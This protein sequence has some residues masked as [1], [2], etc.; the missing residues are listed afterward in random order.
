MTIRWG[1]V[2]L[3]C[4][5]IAVLT[6]VA[7]LVAPELDAGRMRAPLESALR[8]T[9]GRP[10]EVREVRYQVFPKPGLSA[11]DL[12]IP[13]EP[14][15]GLEPLAYVGE[16][17]AGISFTSLFTGRLRISSVRLVDASV[18]LARKDDLG[19]NF[20]RLLSRMATNVKQSGSAPA[21]E[22]RESRINF[23][24]GT[25][26]SPLFLNGVDLDIDPPDAT[27]G[28]LQ[29]R[30]EASPARTDR[31]EEGFGRFTGSGKW[32]AAGG[33]DGT[34]A[35]ELELDRSPIGEFLTLL[36]GHDLGVQGRFSTRTSLDGPLNNMTVK[37]SVELE[38]V[39]RSTFFGL[40][41]NQWALAYEGTLNL[42]GETLQIATRKPREKAPLPLMVQLECRRLLLDPQWSA[43][44]A[45]DEIPA[46]ALLDFGRRLG[47]KLPEELTVLGKVV[48]SITYSQAKPLEG[49]VELREGKVTLGAAGPLAFETAQ[50]SLAGEGVSLAPVKVATP[51][52]HQAE[53]SGAWEMTSEALSFQIDSEGLA[54]TELQAAISS[55][56]DVA[57]VPLLAACTE[58]DL[59]GALSY[60]RTAQNVDHPVAGG[61]SG[62]VGLDRV[63][64]ALD[65]AAQPV[66]LEAGS[67]ALK[68]TQW[69]L[70]KA[71]GLFGKQPF[72]LELAHSGLVNARRP[73]KFNLK[74]DEIQGADIDQFL[75]PALLTRRGF[76]DRTLRRAQPVPA[77]LRARHAE[78]D[79]HIAA[80]KLGEETLSNFA[81]HAYWD[82]AA[83]ELPDVSARWDDAAVS[84]RIRLNLGGERFD[85]RLKGHVDGFEWKQGTLDFELDAR[86]SSLATPFSPNLRGTGQ[87]TARS[88]DLG[89]DALKQVS[90]CLDF[91][92]Q[93]AQRLK[94]GCLEAQ[95]GGEWMQ[96]QGWAA[97]DPKGDQKVIV[98]LTGAHR[99]LR[100]TGTLQPLQFESATGDS[101]RTR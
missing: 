62:E 59:R 43:A 54:L 58:G 37:G 45:F 2:A 67:L 79:I 26:K 88:V 22:I 24:T 69:S 60:E 25:L 97:A 71:R 11:T 38:D 30:Y 34:L 101:S 33:G 75:R 20:A 51:G 1:R 23:R 68:P 27:G 3:I 18:N 46:P 14:A 31:A 36:T 63:Q 55:L 32:R 76:I 94:I 77:W 21:V 28:S 41:G 13:D 91:D 6:G 50:V 70:R 42:P 82:G 95:H 56:K 93:R 66:V 49:S 96:G 48:G 40:R 52:G 29:W 39:D 83:L 78:G 9:L 65:G 61:W 15:F 80:L 84:G 7:G 90:G 19:W 100:L 53:I 72:Q 8:E 17:Q 98:D 35:V 74:I 5:G 89:D 44:F 4:T 47:A 16:M 87:F 99:A 85:Y 73:Y 10:V 64:C 86:A 81:G 12:V 92:G 57:S